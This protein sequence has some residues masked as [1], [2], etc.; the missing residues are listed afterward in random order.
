MLINALS[1]EI[2]ARNALM[3]YEFSG[4][5]NFEANYVFLNLS[6]G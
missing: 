4:M 1:T 5:I 3:G 2:S 6:F